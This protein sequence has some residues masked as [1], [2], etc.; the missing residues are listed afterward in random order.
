MENIL[1]GGLSA[2]VRVGVATHSAAP[3]GC[4]MASC[5]QENGVRMQIR[6]L[7][8]RQ[9]PNV[10]WKDLFAGFTPAGK[11]YLSTSA[12]ETILNATIVYIC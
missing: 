8:I 12:R 3:K 7:L 2:R 4:D 11:K 6:A 5:Q 9:P 10:S 1:R